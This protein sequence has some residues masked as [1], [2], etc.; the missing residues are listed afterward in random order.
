MHKINRRA[1]LAGSVAAY[2]ATGFNL[3]NATTLTPVKHTVVI[4][5]FRFQP[6]RITVRVG[7]TITWINQDLAPHTATAVAGDW[8]TEGLEK[9]ESQSVKI[10]AEMSGNYFC[11]FHPNM[12]GEI[13][14]EA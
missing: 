5:A 13:K 4:K 10:T 1:V 7:D 12:R 2:A 14:I 8:D 6:D 11:E 3:A 9:G